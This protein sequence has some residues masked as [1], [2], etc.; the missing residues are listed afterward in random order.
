MSE[1]TPKQ[2]T[3]ANLLA[4]GLSM[5]LV[6]EKVEVG[7]STLYKWKKLPVFNDEINQLIRTNEVKA[8]QDLVALKPEALERLRELMNSQDSRTAIQACKLIM[9]FG[10]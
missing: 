5:V 6:A 7:L 1:L 3:A 10:T 9:D 2:L 8:Y 4:N